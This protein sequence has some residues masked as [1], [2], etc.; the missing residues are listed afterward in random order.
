MEDACDPESSASADPEANADNPRL[1][2]MFMKHRT[3]R[4]F[5]S[6]RVQKAKSMYYV[7]M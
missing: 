5:N 2:S 1:D 7:R 4:G 6:G 3:C